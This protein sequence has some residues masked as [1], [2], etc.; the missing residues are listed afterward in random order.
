MVYVCA[1]GIT[2]LLS[3]FVFQVIIADKVPESSHSVPLV[4]NVAYLL[5]L[6]FQIKDK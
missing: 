3:V 5:N 4:G 6:Y 1:V 2:V